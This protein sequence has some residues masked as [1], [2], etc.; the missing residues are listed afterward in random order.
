M[1]PYIQDTTE[2]LSRILK[3]YSISSYH[4][5]T[6]KLRDLLVHPKDK[7][8]ACEK[9]NVVYEVPCKNCQSVYIGETGR[10]LSIRIKEHS[11]DV[12]KVTSSRRFTRN[13]CSQSLVERNKSAITDHVMQENHVIDFDNVKVLD[14]EDNRKLR[15]IK[16]AIWIR[17]KKDNMNRDQG[18]HQLHHCYDDIL[19]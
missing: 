19:T 11:E 13:S 8:S 9:S 7:L 16:E 14:R 3:S 10:L 2:K 4:K 1:L 6:N 15:C 18:G 12:N 5:P 17:C